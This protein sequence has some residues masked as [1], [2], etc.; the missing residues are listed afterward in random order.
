MIQSFVQRTT[1]T[2]GSLQN[3]FQPGQRFEFGRIEDNQGLMCSITRLQGDDQA[4][5]GTAPASC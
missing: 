1:D 4:F 5:I 2:T 3:D